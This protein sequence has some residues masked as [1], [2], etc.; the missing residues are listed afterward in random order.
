MNLALVFICQ[1]VFVGLKAFQQRSV[2]FDNYRW[3]IPTSLAMAS[4]EVYVVVVIAQSG[5]SWL[6]V[7]TIGVASGAG[8]LGAM[9]LHK[10]YALK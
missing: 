8:A 2:A 5:W 9:I 6:V 10:R 3:V 4:V 1:F 7:L